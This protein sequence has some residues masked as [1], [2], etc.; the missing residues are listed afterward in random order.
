MENTIKNMDL[1][2]EEMKKGL[3]EGKVQSVKTLS[4]TYLSLFKKVRDEA[5]SN[6]S[7]MKKKWA[8]HLQSHK[9][10][11]EAVVKE[12]DK[13]MEKTIIE[14][15]HK[16]SYIIAMILERVNKSIK[17]IDDIFPA[18]KVNIEKDFPVEDHIQN[19]LNNSIETGTLVT[20]FDEEHRGTGKTV[21]LI[22]KAYELDAVLIEPLRTQADYARDL[23]E[24]MGMRI[25]VTTVIDFKSLPHYHQKLKKN[26][27]LID[28]L[29]SKED[30]EH[31]K[32]YKLLGGFTRAIV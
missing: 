4:D 20:F 6:Y 14:G 10:D 12:C 2:I 28:E 21:A 24:K 11:F 23:S 8:N 29:V 9:A 32:N 26:G 3:H 30:F 18:P 25:S 16:E 17:D 22:K 7:A 27:Y 19:L 31:L 15:Q 13:E 1:I 5:Y